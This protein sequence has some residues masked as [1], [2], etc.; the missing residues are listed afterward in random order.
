[1]TCDGQTT[2]KYAHQ[3]VLFFTRPINR[4]DTEIGKADLATFIGNLWKNI[5]F[6]GFLLIA[7]HKSRQKLTTLSKNLRVKK[8]VPVGFM[9]GLIHYNFLISSS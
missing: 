9:N 6:Y 4:S 5:F 7:D 1:M 3:K 2:V 8:N